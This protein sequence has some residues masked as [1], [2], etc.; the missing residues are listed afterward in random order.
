MF[1]DLGIDREEDECDP[2]QFIFDAQFLFGTVRFHVW[3][4]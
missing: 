4:N 3:L 1:K 2:L